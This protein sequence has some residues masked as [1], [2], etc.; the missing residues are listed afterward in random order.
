MG[1]TKQARDPSVVGQGGQH[2]VVALT[3]ACRCTGSAES[4]SS[5]HGRMFHSSSAARAPSSQDT[6]RVC[7]EIEAGR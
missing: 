2:L 3:R 5:L 6:T 7:Q 1:P 4:A